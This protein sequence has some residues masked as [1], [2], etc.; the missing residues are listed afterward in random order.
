MELHRA[1]GR[2]RRGAALPGQTGFQV[3]RCKRDGGRAM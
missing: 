3:L 1:L 2:K